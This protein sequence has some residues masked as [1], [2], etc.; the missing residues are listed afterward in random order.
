MVPGVPLCLCLSVQVVVSSLV[1]ALPGIGNVT[2]LVI[3]F[4]LIFAILGVS[5][6]QGKF[7]TCS[8][9]D[10][11]VKVRISLI[12]VVRRTSFVGWG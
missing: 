11:D 5:L 2:L 10:I 6:F 1:Q 7:Q 9:P 8:D 4:W 3:I 12:I